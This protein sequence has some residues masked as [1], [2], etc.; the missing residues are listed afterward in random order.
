PDQHVGVILDTADDQRHPLQSTH[1]PAKV[2]VELGTPLRTNHTSTV[3]DGTY[4]VVMQ[5]VVGGTHRMIACVF[6]RRSAM[7]PRKGVHER[8]VEFLAEFSCAFATRRGCQ[9]VA[10]GRSA[11]LRPPV[12]PRKMVSPRRGDRASSIVEPFKSLKKLSTSFRSKRC[13]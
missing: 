12:R 11:A 2:T 13:T 6:W 10:G 8:A 9:T 3:L 7:A 1:C 5:T 4:P